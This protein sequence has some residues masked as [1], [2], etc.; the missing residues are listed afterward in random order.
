[1]TPLE[2]IQKVRACDAE[3]TVQGDRLLVQGRGRPLPEE[4]RVVLRENKEEV[5]AVLVQQDVE[6]PEVRWRVTA[7][8][9]QVPTKEGI[10]L[11]VARR[12][13]R[14]IPGKCSS[15]GDPLEQGNRYRCELC[16]Q[17]A[18]EVLRQFAGSNLDPP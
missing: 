7:M 18:W 2:I 11:L 1:M 15:C 10:P 5:M 14:P 16:V 3:L 4:L 6:K 17:A 13:I 8:R 9:S 12:E